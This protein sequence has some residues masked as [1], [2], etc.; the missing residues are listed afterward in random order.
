M[1]D[2]KPAPA[3]PTV[4]PQQ[5]TP[6]P[7]QAPN[8]TSP[9]MSPVLAELVAYGQA[10]SLKTPVE[11]RWQYGL[12]ELIKGIINTADSEVSE[13]NW[14]AMLG[15]F[16]KSKGGLMTEMHILR[17]SANWPGSDTEFS[18]F[19]RLV[20]LICETSDPATRRKNTRNMNFNK[21]TE[22]MTEQA[23]NRL[24]GFYS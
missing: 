3:Q 16:F 19:R 5:V 23:R 17:P 12:F 8:R 15:F 11:G 4:Q 1:L 7:Q 6:P 20:W 9:P 13:R 10:L 24:I 2:I 18:L 22:H 14:N 21:L